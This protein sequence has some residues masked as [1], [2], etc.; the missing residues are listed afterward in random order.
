MYRR[1]FNRVITG[2]NYL[3]C[4]SSTKSQ[5]SHGWLFSEALVTMLDDIRQ[6]CETRLA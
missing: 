1:V 3:Q 5:V 4:I 6:R 2:M